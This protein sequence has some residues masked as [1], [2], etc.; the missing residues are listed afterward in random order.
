MPEVKFNI[1]ANIDVASS[2]EVA[3]GFK[4]LQG[5]I[6]RSRYKGDA[7]AIRKPFTASQQFQGLPFGGGTCCVIFN[8][9]LFPAVGRF[10]IV[11]SVFVYDGANPLNIELTSTPGAL[12]I[13]DPESPNPSDLRGWV[14][15][16]IP[17]GNT[18]N[19]TSLHVNP[20]ERVYI[21]FNGATLPAGSDICFNFE[22]DDYDA[23]EYEAQGL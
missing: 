3:D 7:K 2:G 12:A 10:W 1:G 21:V 4:H 11:R 9:G 13:G 14:F 18:F 23:N 22:V 6:D 19:S 16:Q 5:H 15:T 8:K 20:N 17:S